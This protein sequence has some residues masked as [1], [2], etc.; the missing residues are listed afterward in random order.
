[1]LTKVPVINLA[2]NGQ[3]NPN[4]QQNGKEYVNGMHSM[5]TVPPNQIST[6]I[7]KDGQV[8]LNTLNNLAQPNNLIATKVRQDQELPLGS[9]NVN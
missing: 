3:V 9:T 5:A 1:M 4:L 8:T 2:A 7:Q 6:I